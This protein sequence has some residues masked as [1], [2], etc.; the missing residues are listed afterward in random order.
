MTVYTDQIWAKSNCRQFEHSVYTDLKRFTVDSNKVV[1]LVD[2]CPNVSDTFYITDNILSTPHIGLYPEFWGSFSYDPEYI[3]RL[4]TKIFNCFINRVCPNRQSWFY[5][6]IRRGLLDHGNVSYLLD[7]RKMPSECSTKIELNNWIYQK[8]NHVFEKEHNLFC[9]QVPYCNFNGD[10]DQAIVD[11]KVGIVIETYFENTDTIAFSE[12]IF[13]SLQLP[14][15]FMLYGCAG[16]V[17]VLRHFGFDVWDDIINHSYDHELDPIKRQVAILD[18]L[19]I[20]KNV[21]YSQEQLTL[22]NHRC[23]KNQQLLRLL[24]M[25]WPEKLNTVRQQLAL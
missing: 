11:T 20:F 4:P 12:K 19:E 5:Q 24:K 25:Q 9:N 10:L 14:R 3:S 22:F 21:C 16:S 15:P 1:H 8:N 6:F 13:R 2:A 17:N 18:Q 7:Y 23:Q